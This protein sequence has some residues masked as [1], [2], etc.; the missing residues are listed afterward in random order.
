MMMSALLCCNSRKAL[1]S[2]IPLMVV[3]QRL[4]LGNLS[5]EKE[6]TAAHGMGWSVMRKLI[7]LLALTFLIVVS[8]ALSTPTAPS[9]AFFSFKSL[10]LSCNN[11]NL[12]QIPSQIGR[13]SR[14]TRLNLS[15]SNLS[16]QIPQQIFNLSR[17]I[18]LDLSSYYS[19]NLIL[20]FKLKLHKPSFKV[21]VQ[22]LTN[23]KV[24]HLSSINI[25]S[26]VPE[27][28]A[29]FSPLESL[30]LSH[31][32]L[33][34]EFPVGIFQLPNLKILD[35]SDNRDLK[36]FLPPFQLK[37]PLK[38]LILPVT[39]FV[40]ELPSSFGNLAYLE[41]LDIHNCN[42]TGQI[43]YSFSNLSKLVHLD[44]SYNHLSFHSP[45]FS[46]LS[47]VGNLTK[48]TTLG[49][50]GFNL[51]GEVPSW[52]M[53]LTHHSTVFLG[54]NQLTAIPS[55]LTKLSKLQFLSFRN[56][57]LY[58]QIPFQIYYL[59]SLTDLIFSSN[60]LQGSIPSNVSLLKNLEV[61]DLHSNN[62]VGSVEMSAFSQ[63]KKLRIL[64]LS[65]NNL[66]LINKTSTNKSIPN[67]RVLGL[68]FC[69]L[70]EFPKFLHNQD[71]LRFLDVSFNN[72]Q[73]KIPSWM[74]SINTNSLEYLNLSHNLLIGFEKDPTV[75]QWARIHTLDLRFNKLRGSFPL[76]PSSTSSYLIS[77]NKLVG[78]VSAMLCNL[79]ALETLDLSF[80]NLSGSLP[81]CL[82]NLS[83][84]LSLLD[85][86]RN[87]FNGSIPSTWRTGC[88]L[89]MIS[90]GYNQLQGQVPKS[91]A[92]CSSLELI[93]FGNNLII[94]SFPSWLGNLEDLR[95][96]ILRSNSFYGVIDKPQTKGFSNLRII[97]LS[98]Q[99]HWKVAINVL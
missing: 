42:F 69:N 45:I 13:L 37:S 19:T 89:K 82:G 2:I 90:I 20:D 67:F 39:N 53:N 79:S 57:Q 22:H 51:K 98:Q 97:D 99:F 28:L 41:E 8:M 92:K 63:L 12:S 96:L 71:L 77:H 91:L 4:N 35:L 73:G 75:L 26:R 54:F 56:N 10:N 46:S 34:G 14:L 59:S 88:K 50:A 32:R 70:T 95:I 17:L 30:R 9:S 65:F 44:L 7:M 80:N 83:D 47:W 5:K 94:D 74:C 52:L 86:R 38:S 40:G 21:L 49:L 23:L 61:L 62:L 24:L 81:Q 27:L 64:T 68:A 48:I 1:S 18:S 78:E 33:E 87:N 11:F 84:S 58:G 60:E 85:L 29:N 6:V 93:D 25:S 55:S 72:I 31:C 66:T 15:F 76:P 43:P 3:I 16:G 36:G